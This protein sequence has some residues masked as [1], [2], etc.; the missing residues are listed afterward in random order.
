VKKPHPNR[1]APK[2]SVL[3][4][5]IPSR[6]RSRSLALFDK[7][8]AQSV[9]C[10]R[11]RDVEVLMLLDN[12]RRSIGL[13]RDALLKAA[14]GAFIV[15]ID[16]DDDVV[17]DYVPA[18]LGAI[19]E[20]PHADVIVYDELSQIEVGDPFTVHFGLGYTNEAAV[21]AEDGHTIGDIKR[22]PW[23]QCPWAARWAKLVPFPDA[24]VGEDWAWASRVI[25]LGATVE[26]RIDRVMHIYKRHEV[27]T[28]ADGSDSVKADG[29]PY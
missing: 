5:A 3:I 20:C 7:V 14:R 9:A 28:E 11:Q 8:L 4:P 23:Q 10:K 2:L 6:V 16:D 22:L 24:S 18:V 19:D 29:S 21:M 12:K 25:A 13:K 17:D 26:K 15:F 27:P 1:V